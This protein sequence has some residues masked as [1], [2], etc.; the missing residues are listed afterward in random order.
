MSFAPTLNITVL[1]FGERAAG[2]IAAIQALHAEAS[3]V[4]P[5][6][7][8]VI[9]DAGLWNPDR[10]DV[11]ALARRFKLGLFGVDPK[12]MI[13]AGDIHA[14]VACFE[15]PELQAEAL[16]RAIAARKFLLAVPPLAPTERESRSLARRAAERGLFTA[17]GEGEPAATIRAFVTSLVERRIILPSWQEWLD[18]TAPR[19]LSAREEI[20]RALA[21]LPADATEARER[22]RR[23]LSQLSDEAS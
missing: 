17:I 1:G 16:D 8:R 2:Y 22:L 7:L 9:I 3:V 15:D 20:E 5:I 12:L 18:R 13:E 21:L 19:S 4:L 23:A 14:V 11:L 10:D 6:G